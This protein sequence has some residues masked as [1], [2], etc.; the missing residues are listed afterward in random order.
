MARHPSIEVIN[1]SKTQVGP[2]AV[3]FT[4]GRIK[5]RIMCRECNQEEVEEKGD[6]CPGCDAY[7]EHTGAL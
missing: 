6:L 5:R 3:T 2:V 7:R 4:V 1:E